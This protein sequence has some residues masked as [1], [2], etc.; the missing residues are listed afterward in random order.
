VQPLDDRDL[1][2]VAERVVARLGGGH[3]GRRLLTAGQVAERVGVE[4]S[5]VYAHAHELGVVRL[6]L[7][8][9]PRLRFDPAIVA[10]AMIARPSKLA[11]A[12][13]SPRP[14]DGAALLPINSPGSL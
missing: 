13:A 5:W 6:G 8:P 14:M 2:R 4:R 10:Q 1:D 9:R 11:V 7:G 3:D 12:P